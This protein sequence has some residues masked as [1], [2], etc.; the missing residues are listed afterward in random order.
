MLSPKKKKIIIEGTWS[1][2]EKFSIHTTRRIYWLLINEKNNTPIRVP[3]VK[4]LNL[5]II[6]TDK[7]IIIIEKKVGVLAEFFFQISTK[8]RFARV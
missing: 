3:P 1:F 5:K 4:N 7:K 6:I 2:F 8:A